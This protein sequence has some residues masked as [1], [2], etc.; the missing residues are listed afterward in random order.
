MK[1]KNDYGSNFSQG[2]NVSRTKRFSVGVKTERK[3]NV[4]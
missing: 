4:L 1:V 2:E 3:P